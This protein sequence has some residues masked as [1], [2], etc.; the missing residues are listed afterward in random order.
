MVL[1]LGELPGGF[2]DVG[3]CCCFFSMEIFTFPGYFSMPPT[4]HPSFS[5]LWR[6]PPALSSTLATFGCF[7]FARLFCHSFI[8][9]AT[10]LSGH[11]LSTGAFLTYAPSPTFLARFVTQMWAG[12]PHPESSSVPALTELSLPA[13]AWTWTTHIAVTR[14]LIYQLC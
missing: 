13:G 6:P 4:L 3:C 1:C 10:V 2:Y 5:G 7:T 11:F 12:I 9:S 8:A 14:P